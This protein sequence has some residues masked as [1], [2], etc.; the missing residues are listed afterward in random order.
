MFECVL[1]LIT[2]TLLPPILSSFVLGFLV[3]LGKIMCVR[4]SCA[5]SSVRFGWVSVFLGV[6]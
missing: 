3:F 5:C 4:V 6:V 2:R 1:G